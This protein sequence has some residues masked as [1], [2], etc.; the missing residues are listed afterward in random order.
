VSS[1]NVFCV[2]QGNS[3]NIVVV[4]A[5]LDSVPEGPGINDNGSG[6]STILEIVLQMN[7]LKLNIENQIMFAWWGS[8]EVGLIGSRNF[9]RDLQLNH[10]E[11]F[12]K[13]AMNLNFDMLGSPNYYLGIH[14]GSTAVDAQNGSMVIT[15]MFEEY[16]DY[17]ELDYDLIALRS[18]SDFVPFVEA[19]IPAGGLASGASSIKDEEER[20][21]FGGLANAPYDPCYHLY[22]DT[23]ENTNNEAL[24]YLAGAAAYVVQKVAGMNDLRDYLNTPPELLKTRQMR[25]V[26]RASNEEE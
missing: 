9:V 15:T 26:A 11:K 5:H 1:Y 17:M 14:D 19:G 2:T 8:E 21:R 6:S 4:G 23:E 24:T 22:C 16:F 7:E 10:P 3:D 20:I 18:G 12:K 13:I 25:G